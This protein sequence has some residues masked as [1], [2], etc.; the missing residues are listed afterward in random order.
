MGQGGGVESNVKKNV[1]LSPQCMWPQVPR[2]QLPC[3]V[4]GSNL[5]YESPTHRTTPNPSLVDMW[6][7]LCVAWILYERV[8][9]LGGTWIYMVEKKYLAAA[10]RRMQRGQWTCDPWLCTVIQKFSSMWRPFMSHTSKEWKQAGLLPIIQVEQL[11]ISE[12]ITC[13]TNMHSLLYRVKP[14][15]HAKTWPK[16]LLSWCV[17]S[18]H[19]VVSLVLGSSASSEVLFNQHFRLPR[20]SPRPHLVWI[21]LGGG[22]CF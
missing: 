12:S 14:Y 2:K 9:K 20:L 19:K 16:I 5:I 15:G 8:G 21:T 18:I 11:C 3:Q 22:A 1:L 7:F 10:S 13:L 6:Q 4:A 17:Q